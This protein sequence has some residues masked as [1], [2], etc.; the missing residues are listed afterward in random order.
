MDRVRRL[1]NYV[2]DLCKD[3][4]WDDSKI[5]VSKNWVIAHYISASQIARLLA[6]KRGYDSELSAAAGALHDI[7]LIVNG[8]MESKHAANGRA[9]AV[10]ILNTVGDFNTE[11]VELIANAVAR[12][13][14]K[15]KIGTWLDE[16]IKDTDVLDCTLHGSD[17]ST[18]EYHFKRV[19]NLEKELGI[20]LTK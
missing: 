12:H 11:E 16:V 6:L 5:D 2:I 15:D 1:Q 19:K 18:H 4:D 7:G 20:A 13:S 8:G 10:E 3:L 17:F 14:E 9:R